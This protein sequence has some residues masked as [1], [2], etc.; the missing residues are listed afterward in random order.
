MA[1]YQFVVQSNPVAG[2]EDEYNDWYDNRHLA[3]VVRVP[4]FT[5]AQRFINENPLDPAPP[6]YKYL[7][8][9]EFESDDLAK[10][11]EH[12]YARTNTD[13]MPISPA[14]DTENVNPIV[15]RVLG[16]AVT[17]TS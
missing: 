14:L 6:K 15:Y 5:R 13:E 9:Y 3:D 1:H 11:F 8:V 10:T 17:R 4:G 7:A 2:R 12:F 16:P